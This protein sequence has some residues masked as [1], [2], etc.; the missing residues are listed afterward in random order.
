VKTQ[1]TADIATAISE[2]DEARDR[3]HRYGDEIVPKSAKILAAINLAYDKGGASLLDLLSAIRD[4]N[5]NRQGM[6]QSQSDTASAVADLMAAR[7]LI[8]PAT[9][10][11]TTHSTHR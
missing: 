2:Y 5:A 4:N 6:A 8:D 10:P 9:L 11:V 3:F 7:E 1:V